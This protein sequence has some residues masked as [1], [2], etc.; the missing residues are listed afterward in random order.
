MQSK[1]SLT[2]CRLQLTSSY[3]EGKLVRD[4]IETPTEVL[5]RVKEGLASLPIGNNVIVGHYG[6]VHTLLNQMDFFGVNIAP[7][8]TLFFEVTSDGT[9]YQLNAYWSK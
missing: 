5:Q 3:L 4:D 1:N 7:G 9:P 2:N 6:V 8:D